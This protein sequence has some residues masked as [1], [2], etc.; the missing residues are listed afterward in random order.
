VQR[1]ALA[2][3]LDKHDDAFKVVMIH[4]P[5]DAGEA[6]GRRGLSD[7]AKVREVLA[8]GCADLVLHGHTHRASLG[9]LPTPRGRAAVIGVPSLS[10]DGTRHPLGGYAILDIDV[11]RHTA[12]LVRRGVQSA[13]EP[14]RTVETVDLDLRPR[15]S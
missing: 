12:R 6:A 2:A 4:H 8:A 13:D 14:V 5:P 15:S 7:V 3:L 9:W 10:S 11:E 1:D